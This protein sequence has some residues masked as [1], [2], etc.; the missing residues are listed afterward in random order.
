MAIL[1][2]QASYAS[3]PLGTT[4]KT[5][6]ELLFQTHRAGFSKSVLCSLIEVELSGEPSSGEGGGAR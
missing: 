6:F 4:P 3:G 1:E 2:F 5:N